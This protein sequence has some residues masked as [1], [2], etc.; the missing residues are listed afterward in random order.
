MQA[1]VSPYLSAD[2][3]SDQSERAALQALYEALAPH[4]V[5]WG[6]AV[7][8]W[9][10]LKSKH[11]LILQ[12]P[13]AISADQVA[14]KIAQ[15]ILGK[16]AHQM[17][18]LQGH[19]WWA[20]NT[21]NQAQLIMMQQRLTSL[22]LREFLLEAARNEEK[23]FM[24]FVLLRGIGRAELYTY[25][26]D[27]PR[28][29]RAFG[30]VLELP[31]DLAAKPTAVRENIFVI[32]TEGQKLGLVSEREVLDFCLV[33]TLDGY[34]GTL[35]QDD[36]KILDGVA[37]LPSVLSRARCLNPNKA[38]ARIPSCGPTADLRIVGEVLKLLLKNDVKWE[39]GLAR[40]AYLF[41]GHAWDRLQKGLFDMQVD[42]NSRLAVE[43]WLRH[44]AIPRVWNIARERPSL[45]QDFRS[46]ISGR[47]SVAE[48]AWLRILNDP[49]NGS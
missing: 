11:G 1:H 4:N 42:E 10:G 37:Q 38:K 25:F 22:R 12:T 44:S 45:R 15:V 19:P 39:P 35:N 29:V 46:L 33:L 9:I 13:H 20:V 32:A 31:W 49:P 36:P 28:Q 17:I 48:D 47:F 5:S 24:H 40:D 30:G 34:M 8:I 16:D 7:S 6:E 18:Q 23:E 41:M 21:P 14:L 26:M 43:F 2:S 3:H 27:V